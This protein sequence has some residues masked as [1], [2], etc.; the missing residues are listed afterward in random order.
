MF[1]LSMGTVAIAAAIASLLFPVF[2]LWM[3]VEALIRDEREYPGGTSNEKLVWVLVL[4]FVQF[5][6]ILYWF[7]VY[8]KVPRGSVAPAA[9]AQVPPA[10]AAG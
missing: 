1:G 8:R 9:A 10:A 2:W 3:L 4:V 5:S 7:M 6:A